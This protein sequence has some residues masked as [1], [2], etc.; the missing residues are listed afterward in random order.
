MAQGLS[1]E[2][3]SKRLETALSM[4]SNLRQERLKVGYATLPE[5][6]D[7]S[8]RVSV[9]A[10]WL[11]RVRFGFPNRSVLINLTPLYENLALDSIDWIRVMV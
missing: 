9:S 4:E 7:L 2:V 3:I 1:A 5:G 6:N 10:L 8:S 11:S